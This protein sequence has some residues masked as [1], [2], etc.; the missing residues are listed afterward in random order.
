VSVQATV[1]RRAA[2]KGGQLQALSFDLRGLDAAKHA[3]ALLLDR[4]PW[5]QDRAMR[6]LY[7]ALPVE[8]RRDIQAQYN[9]RAARVRDHLAIRYLPQQGG[10]R[11]GVRLFGQWKRGIGLMQYP[12]TR[13]TRKGVA[14]SVYQGV[15]KLEPGAFVARLLAGNRVGEN[16]HVAMRYGP[17][18]VMQAGRYKG[19]KRQRIQ[20]EY[21]STV[22]QMLAQ[23]RRPERLAEWA[24]RYLAAEVDRQIDSYLRGRGR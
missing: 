12:G 9:I 23:G 13:Q 20:T 24:T 1:V 10:R 18:V 2:S 21:R 15:R 5:F 8:A 22:A 11:T 14:Y 4:L 19:Q 16:Q 7:R 3:P 6:S 17:K